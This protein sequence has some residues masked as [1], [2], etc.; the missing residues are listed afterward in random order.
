[1]HNFILT[2]A[3][4]LLM[5]LFLSSPLNYIHTGIAIA[6]EYTFPSDASIKISQKQLFV[7]SVF[8]II[9]SLLAIFGSLTALFCSRIISNKCF[10]I[11]LSS[12]AFGSN[13]MNVSLLVTNIIIFA[14]ASYSLYYTKC[15]LNNVNHQCIST[16]H[17]NI[18]S[19]VFYPFLLLCLAFLQNSIVSM[20]FLSI[21]CTKVFF[22]I[23]PSTKTL[24]KTLTMGSVRRAFYLIETLFLLSV[25]SLNIVGNLTILSVYLPHHLENYQTPLIRWHLLYAGKTFEFLLYLSIIAHQIT[26]YADP[27]KLLTFLFKRSVEKSVNAVQ[28]NHGTVLSLN[29]V[30]SP[31]KSSLSSHNRSF[32]YQVMVLAENT[33]KRTTESLSPTFDHS[34]LSGLNHLFLCFLHHS[35]Y[36]STAIS[37]ALV[38]VELAFFRTAA[39]TFL[40]GILLT[41][42][43]HE[44]CFRFKER[45]RQEASL[46]QFYLIGLMFAGVLFESTLIF[47]SAHD[48]DQHIIHQSI[49][50]FFFAIFG[51]NGMNRYNDIN[52][53]KYMLFLHTSE[54]C[55]YALTKV[56][57]LYSQKHSHDTES[58]AISTDDSISYKLTLAIVLYLCSASTLSQG[59]YGI[60]YLMLHFFSYVFVF[61][62]LQKTSVVIYPMIS[63]SLLN[64]A[65]PI[66]VFSASIFAITSIIFQCF[67]HALVCLAP[68]GV[69]GFFDQCSNILIGAKDGKAFPYSAPQC[70]LVAII[71]VFHRYSRNSRSRLSQLLSLEIKGDSTRK[72]L[73]AIYKIGCYFLIVH[74][75]STL[76]TVIYL[77]VLA[78][79][80]YFSHR[81]QA[82]ICTPSR[83]KDCSNEILPLLITL[84]VNM[85]ILGLNHLIGRFKVF[86]L[87]NFIFRSPLSSEILCRLGILRHCSNTHKGSL[88]VI[89]LMNLVI[90]LLLR[91]ILT[92]AKQNTT[93]FGIGTRSSEDNKLGHRDNCGL[94]VRVLDRI[95]SSIMIINRLIS[96]KTFLFVLV[97][98]PPFRS[99]TLASAVYPLLYL[100]SETSWC[101]PLY[102]LIHMVVL[103]L[104]N[105]ASIEYEF[106]TLTQLENV[107]AVGRNIPDFLTVHKEK[108]AWK[109]Q[110]LS[111]KEIESLSNEVN[112]LTCRL[113]GTYETENP[114]S[115]SFVLLT[116]LL[117]FVSSF[118]IFGR[119]KSGSAS[120]QDAPSL[121]K[122]LHSVLSRIDPLVRLWRKSRSVK[123]IACQCW[124]L[125]M[126]LRYRRNILGLWFFASWVML[127]YHDSLTTSAAS[128]RTG[129]TFIMRSKFAHRTIKGM[130]VLFLVYAFLT[131]CIVYDFHYVCGG[132]PK[133]EAGKPHHRSIMCMACQWKSYLGPCFNNIVDVFFVALNFIFTT[134]ALENIHLITGE[135]EAL[136]LVSTIRKKWNHVK[137]LIS[138]SGSGKK[139]ALSFT[140]LIIRGRSRPT[141]SAKLFKFLENSTVFYL[142]LSIIVHILFTKR[143]T[144]LVFVR[145]TALV[146]ILNA[147]FFQRLRLIKYLVCYVY[148]PMMGIWFISLIPSV[149]MHFQL[150]GT[151]VESVGKAAGVYH[152]S[153]LNLTNNIVD[154]DA[155]NLDMSPIFWFILL[156]LYFVLEKLIYRSLS[157]L[158]VIEAEFGKI[159]SRKALSQRLKNTI[160][161]K[162]IETSRMFAKEHN[163]GTSILTY[164]KKQLHKS[165]CGVSPVGKDKRIEGT[166]QETQKMT[167]VKE[168]QPL[169]PGSKPEII[170]SREEKKLSLI[171]QYKLLVLRNIFYLHRQQRESIFVVKAEKYVS[172]VEPVLNSP[173]S[174]SASGSLMDSSWIRTLLLIR[175]KLNRIDYI[176][177]SARCTSFRNISKNIEIY[178]AVDL[179]LVLL[180]E[181]LIVISLH[182]DILAALVGLFHFVASPSL[183]SLLISASILCHGLCCYPFADSF[184]WKNLQGFSFITLSIKLLYY[185]CGIN[186]LWT[187]M[188]VQNG[189]P[190]LHSFILSNSYFYKFYIPHYYRPTTPNAEFHAFMRNYSFFVG[191]TYN[192]WDL[193]MFLTISLHVFVSGRQRGCY[194]RL[195]KEYSLSE[196]QIKNSKSE[197]LGKMRYYSRTKSVEWRISTFLR[198]TSMFHDRLRSFT[199]GL[200]FS[201]KKLREVLFNINH[202]SGRKKLIG[203]YMGLVQKIFTH[204]F[205]GNKTPFIIHA[206]GLRKGN[207]LYS[208]GKRSD[209]CV[210]GIVKDYY[211]Y[212]FLFDFLSFILF[213]PSY[214][215]LSGQ[216]RGSLL[217]SVNDNLL[218]GTIVV[219]SLFAVLVFVFDRVL[220]LKKHFI[221][222]YFLQ[223]LLCLVYLSS[224][225]YWY[226]HQ[227]SIPSIFPL[228]AGSLVVIKGTYLIFSAVQLRYFEFPHHRKRTKEHS[229]L[230][231][232]RKNES[233]VF[234]D[235]A[236]KLSSLP[237]IGSFFERPEYRKDC[238]TYK[239]D[240][241]AYASYMVFRSIPFFFELKN[242]LDWLCT[243]TSLR[244]YQW[245]RLEDIYHA[246]YIR[247]IELYDIKVFH[248][249]RKGKYNF[250]LKRKLLSGG[251]IFMFLIAALFFPLFYF[252]TFNPNLSAN[253]VVRSKISIRFSEGPLSSSMYTAESDESEWQFALE[254]DNVD[255]FATRDTNCA[256]FRRHSFS[257]MI[258]SLNH[259]DVGWILENYS[260]LYHNYYDINYQALK[261]AQLVTFPRCSSA[262]WKVSPLILD[263]LLKRWEHGKGGDISMHTDIERKYG[264]TRDTA[265][266]SNDASASSMAKVM[267]FSRTLRLNADVQ[268]KLSL[269]LRRWQKCLAEHNT[270]AITRRVTSSPSISQTLLEQCE[271]EASVRF[272]L[273]FFYTP[274]VL[275]TPKRAFP[276]PEADDFTSAS[277]D[278]HHTQNKGAVQNDYNADDVRQVMVSCN[279]TMRPTKDALTSSFVSIYWCLECEDIIGKTKYL[280]DNQ[281]KKGEKEQ[282]PNEIPEFLSSLYFII[283]SDKIPTS[284]Q[285]L[286]RNSSIIALYTTVI[287][288]LGRLVRSVT[289]G[290]N[291][292]LVISELSNTKPLDDIM[293][294]I[295]LARKNKEFKLEHEL[296]NELMDLMR[297]PGRLFIQT[298]RLCSMYVEN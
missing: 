6:W 66:F 203:N 189:M 101:L 131:Q 7:R 130:H 265:D 293:H 225:F 24:A 129:H 1:M 102:T 62:S 136:S 147:S 183:S 297:D 116:Y 181:I 260:L 91:S 208:G 79:S 202:V 173:S 220:Y 278:F 188:T 186:N 213:V 63:Q 226:T 150:G 42:K 49:Q 276:L 30:Q 214:Y 99:K 51:H 194:E 113:L 281:V 170:D 32:P 106:N 287:I 268:R 163:L 146:Y 44:L 141:Y 292:K 254:N 295:Y 112:I 76:L 127:L 233:N 273:Q 98:V 84:V 195:N 176:R 33:Y 149:F 69:K 13:V 272:P 18:I 262:P 93:D 209:Y 270:S 142:M 31:S 283:F 197:A 39:V 243:A 86:A 234:T 190:S 95:S 36:F 249:Q 219:S 152:E 231:S 100:L 139:I 37:W 165:D 244:I 230:Q 29:G 135:N 164:L 158:K 180:W 224:Y 124:I 96:T 20:C 28:V 57:S 115:V 167:S 206:L 4:L 8:H 216:T 207:S 64:K 118:Y 67:S 107:F 256:Y 70:A 2:N 275:N 266:I 65:E 264:I 137:Y 92:R 25:F 114:F 166:W 200:P 61:Q 19:A 280:A 97:L 198:Y 182:T 74:T 240:R 237:Y 85:V 94:A 159:S 229:T 218:P 58:H 227:I 89:M 27:E 290:S 38:F 223:W 120:W 108:I 258:Q 16:V 246:V 34:D 179:T 252:S 56:K 285:Y 14:W 199:N 60:S 184:F 277:P 128:D 294:C 52:G 73:N 168:S 284:I 274:F 145:L 41:Q 10:K 9:L 48:R 172:E 196:Y 75:P 175:T 267:R 123:H 83:T 43:I 212:Y 103:A 40:L 187:T 238:L 45:K 204:V 210:S 125:F 154:N 221:G 235:T 110:F 205:R 153:N 289:T 156:V 298:G 177:N 78:A 144:F 26:R 104:R 217:N 261:S 263:T 134:T 22:L 90:L 50:D 87:H 296:Y 17:V 228:L 132:L 126:A 191:N 161:V 257:R 160:E 255:V 201:K 122:T 174:L 192:I 253:D 178:P 193:V 211:T 88:Y 21:L 271:S 215:K 68:S 59:V 15:K 288:V 232:E 80:S 72:A 53:S 157:F 171:S 11:F 117:I 35:V 111:L 148:A 143:F 151:K 133:V 185:I 12:L 286:T 55:T 279:A 5:A 282:K 47:L 242:Y 239:H 162:E 119:E 46:S 245:F 140:Q 241:A 82:I 169:S 291:Y 248:K 155:N 3:L 81:K 23:V 121:G 105:V 222:K 236:G 250:P 71:L 54:L 259:K 269:Q 77:A 109:M 251:L 138:L 247:K